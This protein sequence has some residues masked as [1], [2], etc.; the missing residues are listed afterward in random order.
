M[1]D[2][3]KFEGYNVHISNTPKRFFDGDNEFNEGDKY[4]EDVAFS[5]DRCK[6]MAIDETI[7]QCRAKFDRLNADA[8]EAIEQGKDANASYTA[9]VGRYQQAKINGVAKA[10]GMLD[11]N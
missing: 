7:R 8:D 4:E 1:T 9:G 11:S 3:K 2:T 6:Q 5:N 10:F